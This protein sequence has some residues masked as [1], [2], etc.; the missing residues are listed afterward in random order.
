MA[1]PSTWS[2]GAD[3]AFKKLKV[4]FTNAP[5]LQHPDLARQ[6]V[7]EVDTSDSGGGLFSASTTLLLISF[8]PVPFSPDLLPTLEKLQCRKSGDSGC[9]LG[10]PGVATLAGADPGAFPHLD[11]PQEPCHFDYTL[12]FCFGSRNEK[13]DALS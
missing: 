12:S 3:A 8:I 13:P 1:L 11:G 4:L 5:V 10:S 9:G 7:V 6:F 2:P